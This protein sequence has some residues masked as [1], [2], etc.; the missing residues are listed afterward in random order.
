MRDE[1]LEAAPVS[2]RE[3][4]DEVGL[5]PRRLSEFIGQRELK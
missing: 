5:R 3:E 1:F 2:E 4:V